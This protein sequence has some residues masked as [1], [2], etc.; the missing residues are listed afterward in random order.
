MKLTPQQ[1]YLEDF[2]AAWLNFRP[3]PECPAEVK[4]WYTKQDG[5]EECFF[6]TDVYYEYGQ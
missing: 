1:Q 6:Q 2:A 3:L 4:E 5:K